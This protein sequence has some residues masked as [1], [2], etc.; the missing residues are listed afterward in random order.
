MNSIVDSH[1]HLNFKD[2]ENDLDA[3][4]LRAQNN[5]VDFL[6]T[7][8]INLEDFNIINSISKRKKNVWCTT[9]IHPINVP[10]NLDEKKIDI[11][12]NSIKKNCQE[13][14]V[15]G[16]G[17]AGLD[18]FRDQENKFNQMK[19]FELQIDLSA[20]IGLPIIIHTRN[21]DNDTAK[22]IRESQKVGLKGIMHCFS[23]TLDLAKVAL[24][25]GFYI[26]FSGMVT[27]RK[28]A[29]LND[30]IKYVPEDRLLVETDSPYL[31]PE[32]LRGKRNEPSNVIYTLKYISNI[33]KVKEDYL[34][35]QT[36]KNFFKLFSKI[37]ENEI[38]N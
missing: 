1:C 37:K 8:S 33:K 34:S 32:P 9:G 30:I 14:K 36:T 17:E 6:L 35:D 29:H 20:E 11:I 3:V 24:D 7:I 16:I 19:I 12:K 26:S 23:S 27:F 18:Y 21:A 4:I 31:S 10:K 22:M 5:G 15:V 28:N 38:R 13:K 2:F 25:A